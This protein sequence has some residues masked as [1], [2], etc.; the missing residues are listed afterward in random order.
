VNAK[1]QLVRVVRT[2]DGSIVIDLTGRANGRGAYVHKAVTCIESAVKK[3]A[4]DHALKVS[5][6]DDQRGTLASGLL[7][8]PG[9]EPAPTDAQQPIGG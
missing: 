8:L 4:I 7:S 6:L 3:R 5:I 9:V 2:P 1:R